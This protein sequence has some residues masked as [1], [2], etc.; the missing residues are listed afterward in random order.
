MGVDD[1]PPN[2][3]GDQMVE[4]ESDERFLKNRHE[5]FWQFIGQRPQ[6]RPQSGGKNESLRD[7][8]RQSGSDLVPGSRSVKNLWM[9]EEMVWRGTSSQVKNASVFVLC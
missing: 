1:E 5:W 2:A 6:T 8:L 9:T 4:R 7:H 3:G